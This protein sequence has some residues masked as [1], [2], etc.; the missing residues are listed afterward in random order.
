MTV[1]DNPQH[2]CRVVEQSKHKLEILSKLG[3][4]LSNYGRITKFLDD[5]GYKKITTDGFITKG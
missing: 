4:S 1:W 3:L 2:I 5:N